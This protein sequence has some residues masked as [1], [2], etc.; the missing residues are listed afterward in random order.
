MENDPITL[1]EEPIFGADLALKPKLWREYGLNYLLLY[2]GLVLMVALAFYPHANW[3][4]GLAGVVWLYGGWRIWSTVQQWQRRHY[5]LGDE[6]LLVR[7]PHR[8]FSVGREYIQQMVVETTGRGQVQKIRLKI[9][10]EKITIEAQ[11]N[12]SEVALQLLAWYDTPGRVRY[13]RD[14][15]PDFFGVRLVLNFLLLGLFGYLVTISSLFGAAVGFLTLAIFIILAKLAGYGTPGQ[16]LLPIALLG[17][18]AVTSNQ[19]H[20]NDSGYGGWEHPCGFLAQATGFNQGCTKLFYGSELGGFTADSQAIFYTSGGLFIVEPLFG[21]LTNLRSY[22][23]KD[24]GSLLEAQTLPNGE[25]HAVF[26]QRYYDDSFNTL[27]SKLTWRPGET[28]T[29]VREQVYEELTQFSVNY[30]PQGDWYVMNKDEQPH[31]LYHIPTSRFTPFEQ[32]NAAAFSPDNYLVALQRTANETSF[33]EVYWLQEGLPS[34]SLPN[35]PV[36]NS[37]CLRFAP[38]QPWLV[39]Y[40][41]GQVTVWDINRREIIFERLLAVRTE[42][43]R[44]CFLQ[45]LPGREAL[46]ALTWGEGQQLWLIPITS[47][48]PARSV[49]LPNHSE[50]ALSPDGQWLALRL[51]QKEQIWLMSIEELF[52]EPEE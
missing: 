9:P 18:A 8:T 44:P 23:F 27:Y 17:L 49:S 31:G 26:Y 1:N 36:G 39:G 3:L 35:P 14:W 43:G 47:D 40:G 4:F 6:F 28:A 10:D 25:I 7:G 21:P 5:Q 41:Q 15:R 16:G 37:S 13:H 22:L 50:I 19:L 45:F 48:Q 42:F 2:P 29:L 46:M 52:A 32:I 20:R 24:L 33:L 12:F 34:F 30:S 11:D 51:S 38:D